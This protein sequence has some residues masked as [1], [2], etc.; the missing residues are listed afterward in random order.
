MSEFRKTYP[1]G[2]FFV[3]L[4]VVGWVNVFDR[5]VYKELLATN[6]KYCQEKEGLE[7]YA[8]VIMSNHLH[9]IAAR[10]GEKDLTELLGRFK[11]YTAKKIL[12]EIKINSQESRRDWM[13][14]LFGQFA[15]GNNQYDEYHFWQ[16]T[17]HPTILHTSEVIR[18]KIDYIHQNPVRAGLVNDAEN[19]IYS[20]ACLD[21]PI[22]AL[23]V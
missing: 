2:L 20:S 23:D 7:I 5:L 3:T 8:Y 1:G 13:L 10:E 9:M 21:S 15:K 11:S 17:N 6:L 19:Y 22:K 18:Q 4:S 16:Y 12:S 14:R